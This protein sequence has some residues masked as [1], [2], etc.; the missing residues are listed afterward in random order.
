MALKTYP[1]IPPGCGNCYAH[2]HIHTN[3][4]LKLIGMTDEVLNNI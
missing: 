4:T 1:D 3:S 2:A